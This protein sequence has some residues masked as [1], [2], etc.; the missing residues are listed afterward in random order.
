MCA[1][2]KDKQ[3][4]IMQ[5]INNSSNIDDVKRLAIILFEAYYDNVL[6]DLYNLSDDTMWNDEDVFRNMAIDIKSNTSLS[7]NNLFGDLTE[8]V[9]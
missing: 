9:E 7:D 4:R 3:L 6:N 8:I 5:I 2:N 1:D